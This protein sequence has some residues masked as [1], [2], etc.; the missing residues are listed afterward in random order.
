MDESYL[1][2][3]FFDSSRGTDTGEFLELR[4]WSGHI[5][6]D[7]MHNGIASANGVA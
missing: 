6:A 7:H 1:R 5:A 4:C 2:L 3:K